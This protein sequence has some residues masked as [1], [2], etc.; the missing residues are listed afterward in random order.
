MAAQRPD[1][2]AGA[3]WAKVARMGCHL[4]RT[5]TAQALREGLTKRLG[6]SLPDYELA[7]VD[8]YSSPGKLIEIETTAG[9]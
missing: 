1:K 3:S 6:S 7:F 5:Q 9:V 2:M 8:G 4:H